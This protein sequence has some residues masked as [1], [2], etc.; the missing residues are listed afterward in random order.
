MVGAA[1]LE[2]AKAGGRQIYSLEQLPLCD[3]PM[4]FI[5]RQTLSTYKKV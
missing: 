4:L 2:P 1:G 3:T 5:N